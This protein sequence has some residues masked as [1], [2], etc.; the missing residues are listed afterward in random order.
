MA[1]PGFT[2][3]VLIDTLLGPRDIVAA[4]LDDDGDQDLV[5][6]SSD[7]DRIAWHY[8][9]EVDVID[10][11]T[12]EV[13]GTETVFNRLDISLVSDFARVV[14]V[15]DFDQDADLD[16]VGASSG[17]DS[18]TWY[19]SNLDE[20][21]ALPE[22]PEEPLPSFRARSITTVAESV[23]T[24]AVAD[25]DGDGALDVVT[26]FL[27]GIAWHPGNA[28]EQCLGFDAT[29]DLQVDGSELSLLG[30]AFGRA[31]GVPGM[32]E[33]EWWGGVDYTGDC[34]I[35]GNDLAIL[36]STGV[37][38]RTTDPDVDPDDPADPNA[39]RELCAYTCP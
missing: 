13:I 22:P 4:D 14:G 27:F 39:G 31:C 10:E 28:P 7:D 25:L 37:W 19:Q 2:E 8:Q 24:I 15:A 30:G 20:L 17:N 26:G 9:D 34:R 3:S 35:D 6:A 11:D 1:P 21:L 33:N 29:G 36:T 12:G 32:P 16:V 23:R 18:V 5:T 38:G